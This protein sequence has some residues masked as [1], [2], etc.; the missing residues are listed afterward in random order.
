[1]A[2]RA[3]TAPAAD[4]SDDH[5]RDDSERDRR[6]ARSEDGDPHG[7]HHQGGVHWLS[8]VLRSLLVVC[9]VVQFVRGNTGGA[10]VAVEGLVLSFLPFAITYFSGRHVPKLLET[11]FQLA[12]VLQFCSESLKLFELFTY[13]DKIVHPL[14]IFLAS[15]VGTY[16]LFGHRHQHQLKFADELAAAG[17]MFFGMSLGAFW[18]L[19]EFGMD[20][21]ANANLQKSN[22]DTMTDILLNDAGAVF[23]TLL[24]VWL[25]R[26]WATD[27]EKEEFGE[28]ADWGLG[29]L[30]N[31]LQK[32]GRAVGIATALLVAAIVFAGW[33]IDR[34]PIPPASGQPAGNVERHWAFASADPG[35]PYSVLVGDWSVQQ[36]GICRTNPDHPWP[37]SEK[38]GVLALDPGVEYGAGR[39]FVVSTHFL[40]ERPPLLT[41]T[42][43]EA[44]VAFGVR[45]KDDYYVLR[46]SVLHDTVSLDRFLHGR[47][48]NLREEHY[49]MR[50]NEWHDL[51][52]KVTDGRVVAVFDGK[53]L[54][55]EDR[56]TD[57]D[58]GLGLWARVTAG[59]CFSETDAGPDP[60]AAGNP[61]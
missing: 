56:L 30:A 59:A 27:H 32:H 24:A 38:P 11:T 61:I 44:G 14:E 36:N 51:Q 10:I 54:F 60:A 28:I 20:W 35:A 42:A 16:L 19:L 29:W 55:Y 47:K 46:A 26:H 39:P 45:G 49:L 15:G 18:E 58:G 8:W 2:R 57:L 34:G 6:S 33:Y 4:H 41:G 5:H 3:P 7:D 1:M 21:F 53:E 37:G 43:M 31:L 23:G 48:R 52:A 50:G 17:A 9:L 13:W 22:A 40:A 25:Y 12:I